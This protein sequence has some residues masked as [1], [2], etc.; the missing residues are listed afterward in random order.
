MYT[1]I[2]LLAILAQTAAAV[3]A[4]GLIRYTGKIYGWL[5]FVA[6]IVL[7]GIR[8]LVL[9][10]SLLD[11]TASTTLAAESITLLISLL[12]LLGVSLISSLFRS[13]KENQNALRNELTEKKRMEKALLAREREYSTLINNLPG[14]AYRCNNVKDWTM[15]YLSPG[16]L[17]VTG[18][19]PEEL[20]DNN[21]VSYNYIILEKFREE[22]WE[23]SQRVFPNRD[24]FQYEYQIKTKD[25]KIRWVWERGCGVFDESGELLFI[26]GFIA[27]VTENRRV[28]EEL[29]RLEKLSS[30]G[31]LA[32]GIAHDFNN[33][34][35]GVFGNITLAKERLEV[36]N[37]AHA[38]LLEAEQ[39]MN[40][41]VRLT[42][43]LLT[44]AKGGAPLMESTD[45]PLLVEDIVRFDLSGSN[46]RSV[47]EL[48]ENVW[49]IDADREQM[50]QV[51]SNL[52]INAKQAMPEG[53]LLTISLRN[54][55]VPGQSAI[56]L[57]R[58]KFVKVT[59]SD[60]GS[61]ID[62]KSLPRIFDPYYTTKEK[63]RGL[64]LAT[65][66]SIV[67]RHGGHITVTSEPG[68]GTA[69]VIYLPALQTT[70]FPEEKDVGTNQELLPELNPR[71]LVMDDEE[72][73]GT[74]AS[75]MLQHLGCS[76][77]T[78]PDGEETLRLYSD[79]LLSEKPFDVILMDLTI[80]GGM[81]GER[82]VKEILAVDPDASVIVSSGYAESPVMANY[83]DY[84]FSGIISKPYTIDSLRNVIFSC[85]K[86][87]QVSSK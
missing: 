76:T 55:T 56:P 34:L 65:V 26:E 20:I 51:F 31:T 59:V 5:F 1:V 47:F 23:K 70:S 30:L 62:E 35:M 82:A 45:L 41:A 10:F 17:A 40:R 38:F 8:R 78:A 6:G 12:M 72:I 80:P 54:V 83:R 24:T 18:Y 22:V 29:R 46:V 61:G 9:L 67:S 42:R 43:R 19:S 73:V 77:E 87:K 7:M 85:I 21:V 58:G 75:R 44:F 79:S 63:G 66:H 4:I 13:Y 11:G 25:D 60:N 53:G 50:Q 48:P 28:E 15:K 37:S 81:G 86:E 71:I 2:L 14:F 32:G 39:S 3:I 27:D 68:T 33:I 49:L 64:G 74:V 69:F 52:A 57:Q 36:G 16:C 84:G